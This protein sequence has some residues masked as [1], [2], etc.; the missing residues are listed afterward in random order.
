[1]ATQAARSSIL[2]V[3]DETIVALDMRLKLE[4]LGYVVTGLAATGEQ[5]IASV[6]EKLPGLVLMDVKLKGDVDGIATAEVIRA[7]QDVPIVFVTAF[8]DETTLDRAKRVSPYGYIVKPY[9]D[10]ELRIAIELA[11]YKHDYERSMKQAVEA[12]E[13]A[14]KLKTIFMSNV[15]HELKTP[16]NSIMG[17]TELALDRITDP[18]TRDFIVMIKQGAVSLRY[19]IESILEFT[20]LEEGKLGPL[21]TECDLRNAVFSALV[22]LAPAAYGKGIELSWYVSPDVPVSIRTDD[23]K[24]RKVLF[25]IVENAVKYTERGY[26]RV[27][28]DAELDCESPKILFRIEDTGIGIS[29]GNRSMLFSAFT[30]IDGAMTRS[31]GGTGIGLAFT[32]KL[33][34]VIGGTIG[35]DDRQGGGSVFTVDLPFDPSTAR[36]IDRPRLCRSA[37]L[38]GFHEPTGGDLAD[39]L[40]NWGVRVGRADSLAEIPESSS[41]GETVCFIDEEEADRYCSR[42]FSGDRADFPGGLPARLI[43][44]CRIGRVLRSS[45]QKSGFPAIFHPMPFDEAIL[46]N[47]ISSMDLRKSAIPSGE[48]GNMRT[49]KRI[50]EAGGHSAVSADE[51]TVRTR[52]SESRTGLSSS[53]ELQDF[54]DTMLPIINRLDWAGIERGARDYWFRRKSDTESMCSR[55]AF[56]ILLVARRSDKNALQDIAER[57]RKAL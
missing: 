54:A 37:I 24:L 39:T 35:F 6:R 30:Q 48:T 22:A 56:E 14:S 36:S 23:A 31:A 42:S 15:S 5:A 18:D 9:H 4:S 29:E 38:I 57:I 11:V 10:R 1:M 25:A 26:V 52:E 34:A 33:L 8:T 13:N 45:L 55:I 51:G 20:M 44:G 12:S 41:D 17:F 50:G 46:L 7:E 16:L 3:E 2:I 19:L 27:R 53:P 43:A 32:K 28:I 49:E 47:A 21:Y 40:A